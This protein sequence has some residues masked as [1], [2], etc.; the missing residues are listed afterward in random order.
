[1]QNVSLDLVMGQ[2]AIASDVELMEPSVHHMF[3]L[4]VTSQVLLHL[5][6]LVASCLPHLTLK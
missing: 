1:M 2:I 6:A 3:S 4:L 5:G